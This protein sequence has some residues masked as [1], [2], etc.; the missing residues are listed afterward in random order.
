MERIAL[1]SMGGPLMGAAA[2]RLHDWR[3]HRLATQQ[4]HDRQP[5]AAAP[6]VGLYEWKNHRLAMQTLDAA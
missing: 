2:V 4:E 5:G 3:N 6:R 1:L